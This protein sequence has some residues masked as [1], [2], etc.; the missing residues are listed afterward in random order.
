M[1]IARN[2]ASACLRRIWQSSFQAAR[3]PTSAQSRSTLEYLIGRKAVSTNREYSYEFR[4]SLTFGE[5]VR[6]TFRV[7]LEIS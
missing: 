6:P 7:D 2:R 3:L 5:I 4:K 1:A